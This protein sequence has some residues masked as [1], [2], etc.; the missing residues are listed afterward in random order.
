L[1]KLTPDFENLRLGDDSGTFSVESSQEVLRA[2]VAMISRTRRTLEIVSRHLDPLIYDTAE[3]AAGLRQ[4]IIDSRR[5]RVRIIVMDSTP[6]I[7][8]GHRLIDLSQRL[9][10]YIELRN[11]SRD[12]AN[13]NSAFLLADGIG[14]VYRVLADRFE[15]VVNFNDARTAQSLKEQFEEMWPSATPD[16]NFRRLNI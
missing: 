3:F 13:Y 12:H 8:G 6:I 11:P 14:S 4:L 16:P 1:S 9:S 15:G 5:A 7:S 2:S 10:S